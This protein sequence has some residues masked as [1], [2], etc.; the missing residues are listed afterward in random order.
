MGFAA[1]VVAGLLGGFVVAPALGQG[2]DIKTS[3]G[4]ENGC[5]VG[6]GEQVEADDF[7]LLRPDGI[8]A[9]ASACEFVQALTAKDGSRVVTG[10]CD[11]EGQEGKVVGMFSITGS[12]QDP[13]ALVVY[14]GDGNLWGEVKPCP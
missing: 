8:S 2:L 1:R 12:L 14:D 6:R 10:L 7:L 11:E 9:F 13:A 5:K 3:Y 4:N